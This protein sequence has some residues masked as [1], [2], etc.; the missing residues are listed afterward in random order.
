MY[1]YCSLEFVSD[2]AWTAT[3]TTRSSS[4]STS[5]TSDA[6]AAPRNQVK[7]YPQNQNIKILYTYTYSYIH[8]HTFTYGYI[9]HTTC[10]L[11]V[12]L[13]GYACQLAPA[14]SDESEQGEATDGGTL[15]RKLVNNDENEYNHNFD[16]AYCSCNK[17]CV[18]VLCAHGVCICCVHVY[19]C[20]LSSPPLCSSSLLHSVP[21][22][23]SSLP[24][25]NNYVYIC[26]YEEEQVMYQCVVC[27]DW[28]H[29][30]CIEKEVRNLPLGNTTRAYVCAFVCV[31]C[32][33]CWYNIHHIA[34]RTTS[35][36]GHNAQTYIDSIRAYN[37]TLT[38]IAAATT[39]CAGPR[40]S[41]WLCVYGLCVQAALFGTIFQAVIGQP[42]RCLCERVSEWESRTARVRAC[43]S[44][45]F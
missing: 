20:L 5:A 15:R 14:A 7:Q 39:S 22:P 32:K 11:C 42:E 28:F 13:Q 2:A 18:C 21:L 6:T 10:S 30:E 45:K 37:H 24:P 38:H 19:A 25:H 1:Y 3:S 27:L 36:A 17:K 16:G 43:E 33:V 8:L 23:R 35:H 29:S 31:V 26:S 40:H 41:L 9:P 44:V 12:S 4:C 34:S